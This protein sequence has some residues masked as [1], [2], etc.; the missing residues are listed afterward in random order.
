MDAVTE[1]VH[2][3]THTG[4]FLCKLSMYLLL[5]LKYDTLYLSYK[6]IKF[7]SICFYAQFQFA[8]KKNL[9]GNNWSYKKNMVE[10]LV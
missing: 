9:S 1:N 2:T 8:H 3:L 10:K 4:K 5:K 7:P 6:G